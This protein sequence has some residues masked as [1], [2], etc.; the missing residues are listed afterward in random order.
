MKLSLLFFIL[1]G[2]AISAPVSAADTDGIKSANLKG[3][4]VDL[5]NDH[6]PASELK[7]FE[8]LDGYQANLFSTL[9]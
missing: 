2:L 8:L 3:A 6:D 5:M 1:A 7:N 4:D 9:R